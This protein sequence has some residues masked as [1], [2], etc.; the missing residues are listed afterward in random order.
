MREHLVKPVRRD[1]DPATENGRARMK[2][3]ERVARFLK[4]NQPARYCDD[5]LAYR[6][7][8]AKRQQAQQATA[9][10]AAAPGFLREKGKCSSC[11]KA[12]K[13]VSAAEADSSCG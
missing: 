2:V 5:C 10:L 8:L 7:E 13:L 1:D 3:P 4:N 9:A 11:G 12:A 6:L